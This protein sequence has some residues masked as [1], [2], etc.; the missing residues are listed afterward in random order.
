MLTK[1][2]DFWDVI[3]YWLVTSYLISHRCK[4]PPKCN[5]LFTVNTSQHSRGLRFSSR[6][7]I[8]LNPT[9]WSVLHELLTQWLPPTPIKYSPSPWNLCNQ[10]PSDLWNCTITISI[11][12]KI[13]YCTLFHNLIFIKTSACH[14][15]PHCTMARGFRYCMCHSSKIQTAL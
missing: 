3:L 8:P 13:R 9:G 14:K 10:T 11:N 15:L 7:F 5:K 2:L 6:M 1:I 4:L 12:D